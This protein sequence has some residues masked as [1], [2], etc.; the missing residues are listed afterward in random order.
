MLARPTVRVVAVTVMRGVDR[1]S[2]VKTMIAVT[3]A[4]PKPTSAEMGAN[5]TIV[6]EEK[7]A[8]ISQI[9]GDGHRRS[10]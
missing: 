4:A 2:S 5:I 9:H 6:A 3:A 7:P 1:M 10:S 8:A